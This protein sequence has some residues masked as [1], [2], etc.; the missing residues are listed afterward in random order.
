MIFSLHRRTYEYMVDPMGIYN[1]MM[2]GNAAAGSAGTNYQ[3]SMPPVSYGLNGYEQSL[4]SNAL[5]S[6]SNPQGITYSLSNGLESAADSNE[7][8]FNDYDDEFGNYYLRNKP[9]TTSATKKTHKVSSFASG[10]ELRRRKSPSLRR[11]SADI[12]DESSTRQ[13][14]DKEQ[15]D[16]EQGKALRRVRRQVYYSSGYNGQP[17]CHG[18]PLE[19]NVKSRVKMDQMFPIYGNSQM[20]KCIRFE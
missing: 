12:M 6:G 16:H 9:S 19:I 15:V 5:G 4:K 1:S 14:E 2:M 11:S 7:S 10:S 17:N 13:V 3:S 8:P 20:K 18:F